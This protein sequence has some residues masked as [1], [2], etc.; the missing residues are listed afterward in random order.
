MTCFHTVH[1]ADRGL[2]NKFPTLILS[3]RDRSEERQPDQPGFYMFTF[4]GDEYSIRTV[5]PVS[6]FDCI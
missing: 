3:R 2:I 1:F 4:I 5:M 6:N